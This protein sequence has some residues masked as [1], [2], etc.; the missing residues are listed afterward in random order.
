MQ[1][2]RSWTRS[3]PTTLAPFTVPVPTRITGELRSVAGDTWQVDD[4]TVKL[5]PDT[6]IFQTKGAAQPGAW[7]LVAGTKYETYLAAEVVDV[8]RPAG[9]IPAYEL[10]GALG[11]QGGTFWFIGDAH[12]LVTDATKKVGTLVTGGLVRAKVRRAG[13]EVEALEIRALAPNAESVPVAIEGIVEQVNDTSW[14]VDDNLIVVPP[15]QDIG[16]NQGDTVEV[17]AV[18]EAGA[19]VAQQARVV[20]PSREASMTGYVTAVDGLGQENQTWTLIVF[21]GS[22]TSTQKIR[23]TAETYVDEDR[24]VI[25]SEIEAVVQ[26]D[27]TGSASVDAALVRLDQPVPAVA[28]GILT[29]GGADGL[30]RVGTQPVWF[31]SDT[32]M[33]QAR[34]VGL[35]AGA[36]APS[37]TAGGVGSVFVSGVRLSNGVLVA[38]EILTEQAAA[39][40]GLS[41]GLLGANAVRRGQALQRGADP[42]TSPHR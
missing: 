17:K 5:R 25:E 28:A 29:P 40:S 19:L 38:K 9:S 7:V 33:D 23:V 13:S 20:D 15:L 34:T 37:Q 21:E 10:T 36:A 32:L 6:T 27:K 41:A 18:D 11:K 39:A 14:I 24:A 12:V 4:I 16:V 35:Q 3:P 30:W 1:P 26:G 31:G 2:P 8:V 42:T 22:H